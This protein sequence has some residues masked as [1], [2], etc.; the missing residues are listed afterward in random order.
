MDQ[1]NG[2]TAEATEPQTIN[3]AAAGDAANK[4]EQDGAG[5]PTAHEDADDSGANL[6]GKPKGVQ[7]RIDELVRLREEARRDAEHW[8]RVA[9]RTLERGES[10]ASQPPQDAGKPTASSQPK[11]EQYV[12]YEE[13]VDAVTDWK[14]EQ[15]EIAV[16]TA[17]EKRE[18][19]AREAD[20]E[21]KAHKVIGDG[22]AEYPDFRDVVATAT[23]TKDMAEALADSPQAHRIAY[24]LGMNPDESRRIAGLSPRQQAMEIARIEARVERDTGPGDS[25]KTVSSAPAPVKPVKPQS[26]DSSPGAMSMAE[27]AEWRAR[28]R[29]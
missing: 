18:Q 8:R 12:T 15:R 22:E 7:K 9:E 23:I 6:G 25:R 24:H 10:P 17:A 19:A 29:K 27:Y 16:R 26:G 5:Q 11:P 20:F 21:A 3:P 2:Q 28:K 13:Y 14:L 1:D 4:G